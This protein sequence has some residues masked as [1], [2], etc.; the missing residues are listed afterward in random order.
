MTIYTIAWANDPDTLEILGYIPIEAS[1][2]EHAWQKFNQTHPGFLVVSI[3]K[4]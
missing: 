3:T 1:S 2:P 4:N